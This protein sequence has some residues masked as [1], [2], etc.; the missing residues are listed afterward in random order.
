M[1]KFFDDHMSSVHK[2][3]AGIPLSIAVDV[4]YDSPG[5]YANET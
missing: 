2:R 5:I 3:L 1:A 4:R